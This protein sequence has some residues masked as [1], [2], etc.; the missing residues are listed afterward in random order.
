MPG[1]NFPSGTLQLDSGDALVLYT[2]GVTEA[3]NVGHH[4]FGAETIE[5]TLG[6]AGQAAASEKIIKVVLEDVRDF[7]G[8]ARQSDDITMLVIKYLGRGTPNTSAAA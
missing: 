6:H 1:Q 4:L 8:E 3:M 2:D 7:V 5:K